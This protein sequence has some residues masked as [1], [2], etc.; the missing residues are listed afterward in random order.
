M[1][2]LFLYSFLGLFAAGVIGCVV[3]LAIL[4]R[5]VLR[6]HRKPGGL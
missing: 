5:V 1:S 6:G 2:N 4:G 3:S